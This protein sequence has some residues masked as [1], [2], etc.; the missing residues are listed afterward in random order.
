MNKKIVLDGQEYYLVPVKDKEAVFVSDEAVVENKEDILKDYGVEKT[1]IKQAVPKVSDY[2]E[3]FK[4][5]K[6]TSRDLVAEPTIRK[7]KQEDRSLDRFSYKGE[8]LFFGEGLRE[9]I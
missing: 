8:P 4:Q 6:L 1:G 7:I 2:R 5:R 9:D 3:R